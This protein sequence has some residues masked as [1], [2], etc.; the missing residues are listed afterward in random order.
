MR[1]NSRRRASLSGRCNL[2]HSF[3]RSKSLY[4]VPRPDSLNEFTALRALFSNKV[5]EFSRHPNDGNGLRTTFNSEAVFFHDHEE[6]QVA[7]QW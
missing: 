1:R 7:L 5:F 2:S 4:G 6:S 3:F